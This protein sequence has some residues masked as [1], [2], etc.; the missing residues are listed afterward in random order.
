MSKVSVIIPTYN[1]GAY[2]KETLLSVLLQEYQDFEII[3]VDD[4]STD[5]TA[6]IIATLDSDKINYICL[7]ENHGG[8]S[9]ARNV[10]IKNACG[11][12]IVLCDSDDLML[13]GRIDSVVYH[14]DNHPEVG[15]VCTDAVKFD[16]VNGDYG[17]NHMNAMD[18]SRFNDLKTQ[19]VDGDFYIV[20]KK[21][22][23]SCLFYENYILTSSVTIR[24]KVFD[25]VGYFDESLANAEDWE[26]W[27]RISRS[28][29]LGYLDQICVR[30]RLREGS[31]STRAA[32][33]QGINNI[34]VLHKRIEL[35]LDDTLRKQAN[36]LISIFYADIGYS[37]RCEN[38]MQL[39]REYYLKSLNA[40]PSW[41]VF[42]HWLIS[43]ID[44]TTIESLRNMS[45]IRKIKEILVPQRRAQR[46]S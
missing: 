24:R 5:T 10:G 22:A 29:D 14:M 46:G 36:R 6:E 30:Y 13:P 37:F 26:L 33:I 15:M 21:Q 1:S 4:A 3:V 23:Y 18:Y 8:P 12:Y 41:K 42:V 35:N 44:Y 40:K 16:A 7:P 17:C 27:F 19:C 9:H 38:Q 28:Y 20:D 11:E 31:I 43:F 34:R 39:S 2:I 25:E 45:V 32:H